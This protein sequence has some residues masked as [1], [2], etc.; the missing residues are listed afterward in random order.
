M[1]IFWILNSK[2]AVF[3]IVEWFFDLTE[4]K[5]LMIDTQATK[6]KSIITRP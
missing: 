4:K 6:S 1:C 5:K 2:L 3:N